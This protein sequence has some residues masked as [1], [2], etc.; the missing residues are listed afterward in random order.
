MS[1]QTTHVRVFVETLDEIRRRAKRNR[2]SLQQEVEHI[3]WYAQE[4][5]REHGGGS[6][7][8]PVIPFTGKGDE[9]GEGLRRIDE[10]DAKYPRK[11]KAVAK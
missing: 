7:R 9:I 4:Y 5:E 2:R 6:I 8:V 11:R 3:L 10:T 1:A